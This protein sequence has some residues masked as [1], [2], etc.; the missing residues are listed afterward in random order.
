MHAL[1]FSLWSFILPKSQGTNLICVELGQHLSATPISHAEGHTVTFSRSDIRKWGSL[2]SGQTLVRSAMA[3]W[4]GPSALLCCLLLY[5]PMR[6]TLKPSWPCW[7]QYH[8]GSHM[9]AQAF[10]VLSTVSVRSCFQNCLLPSHVGSPMGNILKQTFS[11]N[12]QR[13]TFTWSSSTMLFRVVQITFN[14]IKHTKCRRCQE[15]F[16]QSS[17]LSHLQILCYF[18]CCLN[19]LV[20]LNFSHRT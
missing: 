5:I 4:V 13:F 6:G 7:G 10:V 9:Q 12:A 20:F 3:F 1:Q 19:T 2:A 16:E 11:E 14:R 17:L 8:P 15:A 18:C